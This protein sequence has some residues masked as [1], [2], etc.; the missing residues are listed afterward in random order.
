M[1]NMTILSQ[2]QFECALKITSSKD[3][4][5][6]LRNYKH[7][8]TLGDVLNT[9]CDEQN[10]KKILVEGLLEWFPGSN[11]DSVDRKVRNWLAGRN[12]SIEKADAFILAHIL[13]LTLDKTNEFLKMSVGEGI[14]WRDPEDIVWSYAILHHLAPDK[15]RNLLERMNLLYK[16]SD[17]KKPN[18]AGGYTMEVY[19]KLQSVLYGAD[20]LLFTCFCAGKPAG[21][22]HSLPAL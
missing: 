8:R 18:V 12:Q 6:T 3:A 15:T 17:A 10:V 16:S 4:A 1:D 2:Q 20:V 13:A 7:F 9:F 5:E 14:H 21:R 11:R 22:C 19:E